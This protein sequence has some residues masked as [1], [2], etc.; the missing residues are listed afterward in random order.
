MEGPRIQF[1]LI[2]KG[3]MSQL[4]FGIQQNPSWDKEALMPVKDWNYQAGKG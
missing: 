4:I 1:L 3:W 2:P